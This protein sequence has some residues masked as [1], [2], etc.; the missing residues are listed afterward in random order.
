[1]VFGEEGQLWTPKNDFR[2]LQILFI[3]AVKTRDIKFFSTFLIHIMTKYLYI[4]SP[5]HF[6][7]TSSLRS[8]SL[9]SEKCIYFEFWAQ[10]FHQITFTNLN[11]FWSGLEKLS[12]LGPKMPQKRFKI[13]DDIKLPKYT[14]PNR[15]HF[16]RQFFSEARPTALEFTQYLN[17]SILHV[18]TVNIP[19]MA[20]INR[21]KICHCNIRFNL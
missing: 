17:F 15:E 8:T 14:G 3:Q 10:K 2:R 5:N 12:Y 7:G 19:N 13:K 21:D 4:L 18:L 20:N 9:N 16:W 1:M 11:F 6:L